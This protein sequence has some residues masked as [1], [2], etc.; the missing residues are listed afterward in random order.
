MTRGP[1]YDS[2]LAIS[3]IITGAPTVGL[4]RLGR[5]RPLNDGGFQHPT[6]AK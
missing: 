1:N 5:P 4:E 6:N 3:R 2:D